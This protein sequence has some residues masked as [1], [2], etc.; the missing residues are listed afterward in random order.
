MTINILKGLLKIDDIKNHEKALEKTH[1]RFKGRLR[2]N[3]LINVI[4]LVIMAI[5]FFS[6][7]LVTFIFNAYFL[8]LWLIFIVTAT[9]KH[10][11]IHRSMRRYKKISNMPN[12]KK[13][14]PNY[15]NVENGQN[16]IK[17][18]IIDSKYKYIMA[19]FAYKEPL[20]L[21]VKNL[22]NVSSI[23]GSEDT[24]MVVSLEERTPDLEY[25]ITTLS[26]LFESKF[27][28]I[29]ITVHPF[30]VEGE[31]PG[32]CSNSNYGMRQLFNHLKE[33]Q[34]DFKPED[35]IITN[36]DV[37]TLFDKN[38]LNILKHHANKTKYVDRVV[39]QPLLYYNWDFNRLSF[40]T[41]VVGIM[42]STM[43]AGAL[44]TFNINIMSVYSASLKLYIDG[45][46]VHP[47]YQ[48]DDII[49]YIRWMTVSK[50]Y[51]KIKSIYSATISGP[52]SGEN[53][54]IELQELIRQS[55]RW[56]IG[57]AEVFHYFVVKIKRINPVI[58]L[59]WAFNYLNYYACFL[60]AQG[61]LSIT[62]LI[63]L[64]VFKNDQEIIKDWFFILICVAY[65]LNLWMILLN[66]LAV[67]TFLR[68]LN[69]KEHIDS[70]R[71]LIHW[72]LSVPTQ[73]FYSF[74][75]FYGF[76]VL[77]VAGKNVCKHGASKKDALK[78]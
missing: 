53:M 71:E 37:D 57:S 59:V 66:K 62:T 51:I 64:L 30:G 16:E 14:T 78:F 42:R 54:F 8:F 26:N 56:A 67:Y 17:P 73:I 76:F 70:I 12:P 40:F 48:M 52:T 24:I 27:K 45:N 60:C 39:W 25:K 1:I 22:N 31:I 68:D 23:Y 21:L 41:R 34:I 28:E 7:L 13:I 15:G 20:G 47:F 5:P 69:V 58:S 50:N 33:T 77:I 10:F 29:V 2:W 18:T 35:Y 63:R 43:M 6:P 3:L 46:F 38:F 11:R 74:I 65:G 19:T 55:Q 32:K 72:V 4:V 49:C 36:F 9:V 44:T 61:F 75:V